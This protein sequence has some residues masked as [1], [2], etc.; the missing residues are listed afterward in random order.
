MEECI[1]AVP[2]FCDQVASSLNDGNTLDEEVA[3]GL[4]ALFGGVNGARSFFL[5]YN[6]DPEW[7]MADGLQ[8]PALLL[9]A[10]D[11]ACS[12]PGPTRFYAQT[13]LMNIA[14]PVAAAVNCEAAGKVPSEEYEAAMRS[15]RRAAILAGFIASAQQ[16]SRD[17]LP[18]VLCQESDAFGSALQ[19]ALGAEGV[20]DRNWSGLIQAGGYDAGQL[21]AIAEAITF[22]SPKPA[23]QDPAA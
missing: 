20:T 22:S 7:T 2:F 4:D 15:Y 13:L 10:I 14:M 21:K 8:P 9:S 6:S 3:F 1:E 5:V 23:S 19:A 17:A 12:A 11:K 16:I 18:S